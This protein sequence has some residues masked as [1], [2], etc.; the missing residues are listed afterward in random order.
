MVAL[1]LKVD[2]K[3]WPNLTA[4]T[5]AANCGFNP[6]DQ[7]DRPISRVSKSGAY[8]FILVETEKDRD[9]ESLN[10]ACPA[11]R[12]PPLGRARLSQAASSE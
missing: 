2:K 1:F 11:Q 4:K 6:V 8:F 7:L 12:T 5:L 9:G 10:R 3:S